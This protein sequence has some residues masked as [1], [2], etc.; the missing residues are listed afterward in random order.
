MCRFKVN[1]LNTATKLRFREA[2]SCGQ[3]IVDGYVCKQSE[4]HP[5]EYQLPLTLESKQ[6]IPSLLW[7]NIKL[8]SNH[9]DEWKFLFANATSDLD[10][11]P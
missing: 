8:T 7:D 2:K 5:F 1:L 4:L 6:I 10:N 11:A 9:I 3:I